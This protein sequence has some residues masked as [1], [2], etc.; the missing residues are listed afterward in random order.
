VRW[1]C[2]NAF[3]S[4]DGEVGNMGE[5]PSLVQM[6]EHNSTGYSVCAAFR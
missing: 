1:S 4:V 5:V 6:V 2:H 3:Q